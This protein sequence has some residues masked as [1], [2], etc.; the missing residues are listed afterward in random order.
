[1]NWFGFKNDF[2]SLLMFQRKLV[3]MF[4]KLRLVPCENL[5]IDLA[6]ES[7]FNRDINTRDVSQIASLNIVSR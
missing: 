1:M 4:L 2:P 5:D 3:E 6:F 7:Q